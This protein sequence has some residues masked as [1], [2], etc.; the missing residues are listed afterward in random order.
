MAQRW[1]RRQYT[2]DAA[3][4]VA[5][6]SWVARGSSG[7]RVV[8][9]APFAERA[10]PLPRI[11]V[12]VAVV[13]RG[14]VQKQHNRV[15]A[16]AARQAALQRRLQ[17]GWVREEG[18]GVVPT[19][20]ASTR[21]DGLKHAPL[22]GLCRRVRR[23]WWRWRRFGGFR[24]PLSQVCGAMPRFIAAVRHAAQLCLRIRQVLRQRLQLFVGVVRCALCPQ[25]VFKQRRHAEFGHAQL[26]IGRRVD[27]SGWHHRPAEK[28]RHARKH[29]QL[30]RGRGWRLR[31]TAVA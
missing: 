30:V 1:Q 15:V 14:R 13:E 18:R 10:S 6:V 23:F 16:G 19:T 29:R 20:G 27:A 4:A 25:A 28:R 3:R 11:D 26:L 22:H 17:H 31:H 7:V 24:Q 12:R 2:S 9:T 21:R 8:Q 5:R